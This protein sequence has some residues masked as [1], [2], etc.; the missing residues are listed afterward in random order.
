M[1]LW[2]EEDPLEFKDDMGLVHVIRDPV[3]PGDKKMCNIQSLIHIKP[4]AAHVQGLSIRLTI[5]NQ[6]GWVFD[7]GG[8]DCHTGDGEQHFSY[9]F[10]TYISDTMNNFF[11][12]IDSDQI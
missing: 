11:T 5:I 7:L 1:Y 12:N 9:C 8:T 10:F 3:N 2:T 6:A 4:P